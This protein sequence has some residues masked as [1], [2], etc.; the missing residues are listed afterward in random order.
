L[1]VHDSAKIQPPK[2]LAPD[3]RQHWL[4]KEDV[5]FLNHGS[6]GACPIPVLNEQQKWRA[7]LEAQPIELL[8]RQCEILLETQRLLV[9]LH[10]RMFRNFGFVTNA[11]EGINAVLQSL[12]FNPGDELL[13]TNHVYNAVR[14]AMAHA[15]SRNGATYREIRIPLPLESSNQIADMVIGALSDKTRLLVIDHVTSPTALVFP[16]EKIAAACRERRIDVLVDGA[17]A[18][19]MLNGVSIP[20]PRVPF[21]A[22]NLHKWICA[23]KGCAFLWVDPA[24]QAEIHPTVISH[25]YLGGFDKEFGWQGTRDISGLLSIY[26]AIQFFEQFGWD[27]VMRYNHEMAVWAQQMLCQRWNTIPMTPPDGRLIGAM[28]TLR[29]PL[30]FQHLDQPV[31][32]KLQQRLYDEFKVEAPLILWDGHAYVRVSCQIYNRPEDYERLGEAIEKITL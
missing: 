24:R 31:C 7:N 20:T 23:P 26:S 18:P 6:F 21:Y 8:G 27:N 28:A 12:K 14:K 11:T 1:G 16:V 29:L 4:L 13:T 3:L 25:H 10:F 22:G 2:P 5:A 30:R 19:G 17:H 9:G 32:E 15:A